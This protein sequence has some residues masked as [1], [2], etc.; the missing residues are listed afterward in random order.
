VYIFEL[1]LEVSEAPD[2]LGVS[3]KMKS[4]TMTDISD[5]GGIHNAF[6]G[7]GICPGPDQGHLII[8]YE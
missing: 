3:I 6:R 2:L 8:I 5:I 1:A 4:H 7:V